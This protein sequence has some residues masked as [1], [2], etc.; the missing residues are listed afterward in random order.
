MQVIKIGERAYQTQTKNGHVSRVVVG[1]ESSAVAT[2]AMGV[3]TIMLGLI[4]LL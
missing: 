1:A 3:L 2:A 4:C